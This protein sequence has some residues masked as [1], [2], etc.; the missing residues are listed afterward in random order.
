MKK[1]IAIMLI[2]GLSTS[3]FGQEGNAFSKSFNSNKQPEEQNADPGG[4]GDTGGG[5]PPAPI[6]DYIPA[7]AA[8]GLCMA[9]YFGRKKYILT[10]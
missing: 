1:I 3:A 5:D 4:G 7:L 10:K 9:V 6:D 8:V 2:V